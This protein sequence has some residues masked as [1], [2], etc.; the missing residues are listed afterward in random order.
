MVVETKLVLGSMALDVT[1]G[2]LVARFIDTAGSI[3]DHFVIVRSAHPPTA[4]IT[5]PADGGILPEGASATISVAAEDLV[6]GVREVLFYQGMTLLGRD[7]TPPFEWQWTP[8]APGSYELGARAVDANDAVGRA[9]SVTV[10]VARPPPSAPMGLSATAASSTRM[11]LAWTDTAGNESGFRIERSADGVVFAQVGSV[12]ANVTGYVDG[13]VVGGTRYFYR[14]QSWNAGGSS[15]W[16]N[17]A[18]ATTPA[19]APAAPSALK[20]TAVS[21]TEIRLNWTDNASSE[22][23]FTIQRSL[24]G[25]TFSTMTS[26]AGPNVTTWTDTSVLANKQYSYRIQAW[27]PGGSS[28]WSNVAKA[29]TPR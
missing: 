23:G 19:A 12:A 5:S 8:P 27:N 15:P 1:P 17:I 6:D 7:A 2:R 24:D 29:R 26:S 9:A 13:T 14:V 21:R 18:E 16:S 25:K 28:T 22:S 3:R 10:V 11:N 4:I 20:A